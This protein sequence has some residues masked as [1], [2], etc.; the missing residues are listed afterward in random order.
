MIHKNWEKDDEE[1]EFVSSQTFS[2][3][4]FKTPWSKRSDGIRNWFEWTC[5]GL[6]SRGADGC[7]ELESNP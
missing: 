5:C 3:V 2:S 7:Q 1:I 6:P 4:F